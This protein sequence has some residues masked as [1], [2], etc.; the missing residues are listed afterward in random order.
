MPIL[1]FQSLFILTYNRASHLFII[2]RVDSTSPYDLPSFT[3]G[4]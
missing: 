2:E 1:T 4:G 3:M